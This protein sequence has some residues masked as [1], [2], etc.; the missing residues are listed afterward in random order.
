MEISLDV[1]PAEKRE[2][3][4][5]STRKPALLFGHQCRL[6]RYPTNKKR[7]PVSCRNDLQLQKNCQPSRRRLTCSVTCSVTQNSRRHLEY[8]KSEAAYMRPGYSNFGTFHY[9]PSLSANNAF[10]PIRDAV[11]H[12]LEKS[13]KTV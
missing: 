12:E 2:Q 10:S 9:S 3:S 5:H 7:R 6:F 1:H 13:N 8:G 4:L 11:R